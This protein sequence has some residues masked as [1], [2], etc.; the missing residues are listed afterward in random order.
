MLA[1]LSQECRTLSAADG[2]Y[3]GH[4]RSIHTGTPLF[5]FHVRSIRE[6]VCGLTLAYQISRDKGIAVVTCP[7]HVK[8]TVNVS[9]G[10]LFMTSSRELNHTNV[11]SLLELSYQVGVLSVVRRVCGTKHTLH[12]R[13]SRNAIS[14][15]V[16]RATGRRFSERPSPHSGDV[17]PQ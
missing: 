11:T 4:C 6:A 13:P 8:H 14:R 15:P 10:H 9:L 1:A 7:P 12:C 5:Q 16:S 3:L 2:R 17:T